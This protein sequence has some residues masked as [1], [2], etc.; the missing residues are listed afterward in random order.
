MNS[1]LRMVFFAGTLS[2]ASLGAGRAPEQTLHIRV[3]DQAQVPAE[4][5]QSA[6]A[7]TGRIFQAAR[8]GI[9]WELPAAESPEDRGFDWSSPAAPWTRP[10]RP[11]VAVRIL[12]S[13]SAIVPWRI[14]GLRK[15]PRSKA[16]PWPQSC[17][18]K[19]PPALPFVQMVEQIRA[20]DW[21]RSASFV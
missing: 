14:R 7:E 1:Y 10:E 6:M 11:Y 18:N 2:A 20:R 5:L 15:Q 19:W 13:M 21:T 17:H 8:I 3:Y 12:K 4:T 9:V 16:V